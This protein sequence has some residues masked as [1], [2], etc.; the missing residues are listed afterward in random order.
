MSEKP[1]YWQTPITA[2]ARK[3]H[4][5]MVCEA[6]GA[7]TITFPLDAAIAVG[8]G[9][10]ACTKD[11]REVLSEPDTPILYDDDG[12]MLPEDQQPPEPYYPT[13]LDAERLALADPNHDWRIT[14][15]GPL[16]GREYQRQGE[17]NWVLISQSEGF[18]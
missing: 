14:L 15:E 5:C 11:G 2:E 9:Y 17:G 3:P 1:A 18:A 4:A 12:E 10:A 13:G 16:S 7:I 6:N 8:F